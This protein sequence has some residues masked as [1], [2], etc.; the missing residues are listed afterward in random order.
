MTPT[1]KQIFAVADR[2]QSMVKYASNSENLKMGA[3]GIKDYR[4]CGTY[5]C[6]GGWYGAASG[7]KRGAFSEGADLIA[8]HLGWKEP[9]HLT[10]KNGTENCNYEPK[11]MFNVNKWAASQPEIW[12]NA[13]GDYIFG[14][15]SAFIQPEKRP[16]GALILQHI[17]D[18]WREV[19]ER[20]KAIEE[21][22]KQPQ[23]VDV[24]SELAVFPVSETL[25]V[26]TIKEN[27]LL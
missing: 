4:A 18:H 2:L 19:G 10:Y 26:I 11:V 21:A 25:D 15:G 12:G 24:T 22:E 13:N 3:L 23:H 8:E 5:M 27:A 14:S 6:H 16:M 20:V 17:V 1:S 9:I 7:I